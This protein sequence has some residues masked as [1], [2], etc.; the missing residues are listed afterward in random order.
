MRA[1]DADLVAR[2]RGRIGSILKDKW[3]LDDLLGMGGMA[4]V[5]AATHRNGNRVAIKLLEPEAAAV[6]DIR[7]R[8]LRE[9]YVANRVGHPG[10]VE[11]VDDNVDDDGTVFLVMELL[12]GETLEQR[13]S[14][15]GR[16]PWRDVLLIGNGI[17]DVLN[18]AHDKG[19]VHRD[20]KPGNVF[21]ERTGSVKLL[22][23]G[24]ARL[25]QGGMDKSTTGYDTALGTPGF[26]APEQARGRWDE[27]DAQSDLFSVGA[28]LFAVVTGR[29]IHEAD[30]GNEQFMLAMTQQAPPARTV[31]P[32]LSEPV[33]ALLDRAL[34]YEKNERWPN[35]AAMQQAICAAYEELTGERISSTNDR[36]SVPLV[37]MSR[38]VRPDAPTLAA[39]DSSTTTRPVTQ[40]EGE[41][42]PKR[43]GPWILAGVAAALLAAVAS[44]QFRSPADA[45]ESTTPSSAAAPAETIAREPAPAATT[46]L[47]VAMTADAAPV[48]AG[49]TPP[50]EPPPASAAHR[51]QP[52]PRSPRA[53]VPAKASA[54][55][56]PPADVDLFTRRK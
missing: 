9:G 10:A 29:H 51:A 5:Y 18:A 13:W 42:A 25:R 47:P 32:E 17:L 39:T 38:S 16:L 15:E 2:A 6:K 40:R 45:A 1:S 55:P 14:A 12:H 53:P 27:V 54:E 30:T 50:T 3:T 22:D 8:F 7:E 26:V 28:M 36:L 41:P 35:A 21:V 46:S 56:G 24:I 43:R 11:I 23:F 49:T 44:T 20:I 34:R 33:A 31:L 37:R 4:S 52:A 19:I 48:D